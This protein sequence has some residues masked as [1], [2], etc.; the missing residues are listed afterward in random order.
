M[1]QVRAAPSIGRNVSGVAVGAGHIA[2]GGDGAAKAADG[3]AGQ[4]AKVWATAARSRMG[5]RNVMS[6]LQSEDE[7]LRLTMHQ[8]SINPPMTLGQ[9]NQT[10]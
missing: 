9:Q 1:Q 10:A 7:E 6:A 8:S 2:A 3:G 4:M 5:L